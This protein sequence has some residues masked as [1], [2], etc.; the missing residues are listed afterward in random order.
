MLFISVEDFITQART[1]PRL[2][3]E[4]EKNLAQRMA[5]G[6]NDARDALARGYFFMAVA[7]LKRAPQKIQTLRTVYAC[8]DAIEKGVDQFDFLQDGET[9]MHHLSWRM[10]QCITRCIVDQA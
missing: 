8:I 6:D 2:S 10:R 1:I 7:A 3:R 5:A 4:E 9:F